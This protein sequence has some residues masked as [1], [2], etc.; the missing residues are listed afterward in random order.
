MELHNKNQSELLPY[1]KLALLGIDREKADSLPK[2]VKEKLADLRL[3]LAKAKADRKELEADMQAKEKVS[4]EKSEKL[5]A[6]EE[7]VAR[8]TSM[9]PDDRVTSGRVRGRHGPC[10][11]LRRGHAGR[12]VHGR[13]LHVDTQARQ[14]AGQFRGRGPSRRGDRRR[15]AGIP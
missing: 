12:T 14:R 7:Q 8:L 1:E 10:L 9:S 13:N 6:L 4:K 15:F 11:P 5:D 2:E 3:E